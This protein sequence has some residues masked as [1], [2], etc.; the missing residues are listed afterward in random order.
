MIELD[1]EEV[2]VEVSGLDETRLIEVPAGY[3]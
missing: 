2:Q 3:V 1:V